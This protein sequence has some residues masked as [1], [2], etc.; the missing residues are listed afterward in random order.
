MFKGWV[1]NKDLKSPNRLFLPYMRFLVRS[2]G[3]GVEMTMASSTEP[4]PTTD[5]IQVFP[6]VRCERLAT[7]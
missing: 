6:P 4:S 5:T 2:E 7:W 3:G 1:S